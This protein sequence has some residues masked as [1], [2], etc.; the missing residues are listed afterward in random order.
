MASP[1]SGHSDQNP[2]Q[3]A[4]FLLGKRRFSV[5]VITARLDNTR[6]IGNWHSE[7]HKI[8]LK[9]APSNRFELTAGGNP[10]S[11]NYA[12]DGDPLKMTDTNGETIE[13]NVQV[14]NARQL[15]ILV[16]GNGIVFVGM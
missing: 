13:G 3:I 1:F 11:G 9:L 6:H 12:I 7:S 5:F 16:N 2:I 15:S 8:D 4:R 10:M 14:D